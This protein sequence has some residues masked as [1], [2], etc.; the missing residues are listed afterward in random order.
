MRLTKAFWRDVRRR[1]W[2]NEDRLSE[3]HFE[4]PALLAPSPNFAVV[5]QEQSMQSDR[6]GGFLVLHLM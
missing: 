4:T 5:C 3:N 1:V 2:G 6:A